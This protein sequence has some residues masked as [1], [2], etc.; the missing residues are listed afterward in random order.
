MLRNRSSLTEVKITILGKSFRQSSR[1]SKSPGRA[2]WLTAFEIKVPSRSRAKTFTFT[3][4]SNIGAPNAKV[5]ARRIRNQFGRVGTEFNF[6]NIVRV[7]CRRPRALRRT[8]LNEEKEKQ[9]Q[10]KEFH[11][12]VLARFITRLVGHHDRENMF[13]WLR[14]R[15]HRDRKRECYFTLIALRVHS[16]PLHQNAKARCR[17]SLSLY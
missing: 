13:T 14:A 15:G 9:S 11:Q 12:F 16:H 10:K 3:S 6:Q 8:V 7:A 17:W 1:K 4:D 2:I 5:V